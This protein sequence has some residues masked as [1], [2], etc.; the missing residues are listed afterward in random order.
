MLCGALKLLKSSKMKTDTTLTNSFLY[1]A[2]KY[3]SMFSRETILNALC[4]T[5]RRESSLLYKAKTTYTN[6]VL[7]VNMLF[8]SYQDIRQW[9]EVFLKVSKQLSI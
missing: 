6:A 7:I 3:P 4:S 9:P 1:L 8:Y 2:K 5:L